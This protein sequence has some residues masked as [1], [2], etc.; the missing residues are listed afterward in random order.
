M[1]DVLPCSVELADP[2]PDAAS[3]GRGPLLASPNSKVRKQKVLRACDHYRRFLKEWFY[4]AS[5]SKR[6]WRFRPSTD[7]AWRTEFKARR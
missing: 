6:H 3:T 4:I 5:T 1:Y 2:R 7:L